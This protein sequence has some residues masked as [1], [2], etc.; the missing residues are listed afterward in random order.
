M[1]IGI[2]I[3]TETLTGGG[4]NFI[5]QEISVLKSLEEKLDGKIIFNYIFTDKENYDNFKTSLQN[6][7]YF[8]RKS[9]I[10]RVSLLLNKIDIL[11]KYIFKLNL[12]S[13]YCLYK[14]NKLDFLIF[15]SPSDLV[16]FCRYI[17]FVS[18]V[19]EIQYKNYPSLQEYKNIY[20]DIKERDNISKFISLYSYKIFV[21]T[22]K[23]KDDFRYYYPCDNNRLIKKFTNSSIIVNYLKNP[24]ENKF[25]YDFDYFYYPA[26]FWSHKNHI[27]IV[28]A[29]KE[30]KKNK[31]QIKCI[32]SG[33][34][35][36]N[37]D[38]IKSEIKK[39][40]LEEYF[41]FHSYL[42]DQEVANLYHNSFCILIPSLVGTYTFPHIESF[43]FK[44]LI[45]GTNKN[46][47]EDFKNRIIN[48]DLNDPNDLYKKYININLD[49]DFEKK[50]LDN[51]KKFYDEN[52]D[53]LIAENIFKKIILNFF[54]EKNKH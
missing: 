20:H 52:F 53:N 1:K 45:I 15:I 31:A 12:N 35:K 13:F 16:Y 2:L 29:F 24:I 36:G 22:Q 47:D 19:W 6:T 54:D 38:K 28:K 7:V 3:D 44:K 49:G 9:L 42:T 39:N 10:N 26:Q 11:R 46:L 34:D 51:N 21:G 25:N 8:N 43:F 18:T 48:I 50:I 37:L 4:S 27:Y 17:D 23:S 14:K 33:S 32:F 5:N 41:I 30:F 40:D